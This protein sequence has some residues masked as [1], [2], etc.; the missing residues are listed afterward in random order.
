[1]ESMKK[2]QNYIMIIHQDF[3]DLNIFSIKKMGEGDNSIAFLI[4]ENNIFR[5]AKRKEIKQQIRR[6]ILVL[7]KIKP[8]LNLQIPEF[9]FISPETKFVGY[10]KIEGEI[11]TNKIF[12]SLKKK[13]QLFI[14]KTIANFL[15]QIHSFSVAELKNCRLETMNPYEEY[16]D[17][18]EQAKQLI[19]PNISKNKRGIITKLFTQYLCNENNFKYAPALVHNDFSKD[20]ILFDT[21]NKGICGIIDFGDIA[22]GD[23]D[24]DFMYLLDEFGEDFLSGIFKY[25]QHQYHPV[26]LNKIHFFSLA[27]KIQI[28]LTSIKDNDEEGIKND[29][30][31]FNKWFEKSGYFIKS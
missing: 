21:V 27:N 23:R 18:F 4:N 5:F 26:S 1:M 22:F 28:L 13:E 30:K 8:A 31:S 24:Y 12:Q 7:P 15:Y 10:K 14:Q 11:F 25:Y 20:H 17:N 19:F 3:P 2:F 16:S 6:E 9:G 29:L